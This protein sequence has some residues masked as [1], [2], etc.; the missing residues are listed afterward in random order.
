VLAGEDA[1]RRSRRTIAFQPLQ[2]FV[3]DNKEKNESR[4][5]IDIRITQ[6]S[7]D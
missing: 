1:T 6:I 4:S 5:M 7:I 2:R 3:G